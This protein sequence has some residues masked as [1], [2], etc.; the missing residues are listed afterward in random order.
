M[1]RQSCEADFTPCDHMRC[2]KCNFLGE[3]GS[4]ST[5]IFKS[6]GAA[7]SHV[8]NGPHILQPSAACF[9]YLV[10]YFESYL[11]EVAIESLITDASTIP[12]SLQLKLTNTFN[13]PIFFLYSFIVHNLS[14]LITP[15][16]FRHHFT[17]KSFPKLANFSLHS[18]SISKQRTQRKF[19]RRSK[20][21]IIPIINTPS[22]MA[23]FSRRSLPSCSLCL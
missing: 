13:C 3:R 1:L 5:A 4:Y 6:W 11:N 18:P 9:L 20:P 22:V 14:L 17:C 16:N 12:C 19:L 7:N 2:I 23:Y 8:I 21:T 15:P 10:T